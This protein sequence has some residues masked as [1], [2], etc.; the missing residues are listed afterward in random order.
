MET[1]VG[2]GNECARELWLKK[3][4]ASLP[5]GSRIL[6]AGAGEQQYKPLC[7]HLHYVS[8]DL[9]RY[10]S[11]QDHRGM[12]MTRWNYGKIDIVSEI[13]AIPE[14]DSS[15]DAILCT[16]VFEHLPDPLLAVK[17]FSRLLRQG[18][19]LIITA[20]FCSLTHFAP[21]YYAN[22]FSQFWYEKHLPFLGLK[23]QRLHRTVI[24]SS[25]LLKSCY[26]FLIFPANMPSSSSCAMIEQRL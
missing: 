11:D 16:E 8:Q 12:Q 10:H 18:G 25:G 3:T 23:S 5:A 24:S 21:D 9:G 7:S 19:E 26:D 4:L 14:P 6:D 2:T 15:F 22:G 20:P 17:E 13:D 1:K